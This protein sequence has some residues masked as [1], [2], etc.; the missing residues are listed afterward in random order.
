MQLAIADRHRK[1]SA[2][3]IRFIVL[4]V[5]MYVLANFSS[6]NIFAKKIMGPIYEG[7]TM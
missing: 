3:I 2:I 6:F 5:P 1:Y 7:M 4:I